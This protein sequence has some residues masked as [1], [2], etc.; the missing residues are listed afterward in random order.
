M[1]SETELANRA[2]DLLGESPITSF[3]GEGKVP[4]AMRR[5]YT[6]TLQAELRKHRWNFAIKRDNA[7]LITGA[8]M[9]GYNYQYQL[10][11]DCLLLIEVAGI[12]IGNMGPFNFGG[13]P[14]YAVEGKRILTNKAAPLPIRFIRNV[15]ETGEFDALFNEVL[16][17]AWAIATCNAIT[18]SGALKAELRA[19]YRLA[20]REAR[21]ANCIERPNEDL[22][23][24]T[25]AAARMW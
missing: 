15:T 16:A 25:W 2:L 10:P 13:L 21:L 7:G 19:E 8:P 11:S 17:H 23:E 6:P 1:A 9:S 12:S 20:L 3:D 14:D 18:G 4:E 22:A 5:N 24:G